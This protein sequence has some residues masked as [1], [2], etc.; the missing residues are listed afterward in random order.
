MDVNTD[1]QPT[2]FQEK[3]LFA[4]MYIMALAQAIGKFLIAP[5]A[6]P[7]F[8]KIERHVTAC[9]WVVAT[10]LIIAIFLAT[11]FGCWTGV[12]FGSS[13]SISSA[14]PANWLAGK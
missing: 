8:D 2:L 3:L 11:I 1:D 9:T 10:V 7:L 5:S 14:A 12:G 4:A 13:C 6:G